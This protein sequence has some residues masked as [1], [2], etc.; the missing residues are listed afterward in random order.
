MA[1]VVRAHEA[2]REYGL[3]LIIGSEFRLEDGSRLVLL[4]PNRA[5]YGQICRLITITRRRAGKGEYRLEPED[6]DEELN[7]TLAIWK[8]RQRPAPDHNHAVA[9]P[10]NQLTSQ[11][12]NEALA[13]RLKARF[14]GRLWLGATRL[15]V[16]GERDWFDALDE[17]GRRHDI[18]RL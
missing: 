11:P 9:Q 18:P 12:T 5:A 16:P 2:A 1:G 8:P 13:A 7:D 3:R 14:G 17:L 4:A 6:L 15:L 10:A